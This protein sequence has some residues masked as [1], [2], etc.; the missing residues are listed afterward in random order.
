MELADEAKR[1]FVTLQVYT[2]IQHR[3]HRQLWADYS[4]Q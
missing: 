4:N 3:A 1:F 2:T